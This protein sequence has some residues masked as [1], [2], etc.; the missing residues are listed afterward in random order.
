VVA[1]V[2]VTA[3]LARLVAVMVALVTLTMQLLVL[4]VQVVV[5]AEPQKVADVILFMERLAVLVWL[6]LLIQQP[7]LPYR[8]S[9]VD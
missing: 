8:L 5:V 7:L 6:S 9:V 1:V 4:L 2:L 3:E